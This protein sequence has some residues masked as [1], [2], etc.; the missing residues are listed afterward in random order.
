MEQLSQENR[1]RINRVLKHNHLVQKINALLEDNGLHDFTVKILEL[2]PRGEAL[3]N[4][5]HD[6]QEG[7]ELQ[8]VCHNGT[9]CEMRCVP[10]G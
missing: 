2:Q 1:D 3:K 7:Y 9:S 10:A 4:L 8:W 5:P 6:C